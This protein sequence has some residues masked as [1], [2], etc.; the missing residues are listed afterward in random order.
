MV[1]TNTLISLRVSETLINDTD[2]I[3]KQEGYNSLQEFIRDSWRQK[4]EDY[5]LR[6]A[7]L[8]L[9]KLYGSSKEKAKIATKKELEKHIRKVFE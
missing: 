4:V 3:I 1:M 5:K 6:K 9:Q 2:E 7:M 8:E